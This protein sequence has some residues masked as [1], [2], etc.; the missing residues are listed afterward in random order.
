MK[1]DIKTTKRLF[2]IRN[3]LRLIQAL[4]M[5][6]GNGKIFDIFNKD[7]IQNVLNLKTD[8]EI[9]KENGKAKK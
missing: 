6:P 2:A 3:H 8:E 5:L 7:N 4:S 9:K 1:P